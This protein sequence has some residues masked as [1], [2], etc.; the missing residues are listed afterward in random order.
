MGEPFLEDIRCDLGAFHGS[1]IRD[2]WAD[3]RNQSRNIAR[4]P[5]GVLYNFH[6]H[7]VAGWAVGDI[8]VDAHFWLSLSFGER[9]CLE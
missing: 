7:F 5:R 8:Q 6:L 9:S 3:R 2:K 1:H 4:L